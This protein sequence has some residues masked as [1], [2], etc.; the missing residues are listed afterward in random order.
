MSKH[1]PVVIIVAV[2]IV[3]E[4]ESATS[5]SATITSVFRWRSRVT[6]A[7]SP[8]TD[9]WPCGCSHDQDRP[10]RAAPTF[11]PIAYVVE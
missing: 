2:E 7:L 6:K 9:T 5:R 4:Y 1:T 3:R 11:L 10:R 8:A